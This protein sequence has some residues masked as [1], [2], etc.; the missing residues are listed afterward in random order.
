MVEFID[1]YPTLCDL[2]GL[3]RPAHLQG[4]S[5]QPLLL[6]VD[7]RH[8]EAVF[9]RH[10]GGDAVRTD[11]WRYTEMRAGDGRGDLL[12]VGLFDLEKDPDENRNVVADTV[13]AE[14]RDKLKE[15]LEATRAGF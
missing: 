13:H 12:G 5:M 8:K 10:G 6:D 7:A 1:I 14:V 15:M 9:T 3:P 4:K 2:A 11:R